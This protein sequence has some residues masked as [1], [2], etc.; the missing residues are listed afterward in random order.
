VVA[1][2]VARLINPPRGG[3]G[4]GRDAPEPA[5][6][7][8]GQLDAARRPAR[9]VRLPPRPGP[10]HRRERSRGQRTDSLRLRSRKT[11][12]MGPIKKAPDRVSNRTRRESQA[13]AARTQAKADLAKAQAK[14]AQEQAPGNRQRLEGGRD[15]P[16]GGPTSDC[17]ERRPRPCRACR[18]N[19][20]QA[21]DGGV[22]PAPT[23]RRRT[24]PMPERPAAGATFVR[25]GMRR[26]RS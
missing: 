10:A 23:G 22:K 26:S 8:A 20:R 13:K 21:P 24:L 4:R 14:V 12:A 17:P 1:Q 16:A 7:R 19:R 18:G 6:A 2:I 25:P 15:A 9:T 11:V 3:P 5:A